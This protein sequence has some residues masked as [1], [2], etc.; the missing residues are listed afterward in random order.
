MFGK[1]A[2][3]YT[4]GLSI[5]KDFSKM[6]TMTTWKHTWDAIARKG[7]DNLAPEDAPGCLLACEILPAFTAD[8]IQTALRNFQPSG[9]P[10]DDLLELSMRF[11]E[12][13]KPHRAGLA[14]IRE[15]LLTDPSRLVPLLLPFAGEMDRLVETAG[16]RTSPRAGIFHSLKLMAALAKCFPV[17]LEDTTPELKATLAC[18]AQKLR[19]AA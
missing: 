5:S 19:A 2:S 6:A 9:F 8:M 17:F 14:G 15:V 1:N 10:H 11:L 16:L 4:G 7:F 18:L 13:M 12:A 3:S